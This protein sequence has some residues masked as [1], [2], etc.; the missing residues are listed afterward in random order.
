M[1][2]LFVLIPVSALA[3]TA[4]PAAYSGTPAVFKMV[5]EERP[6]PSSRVLRPHAPQDSLTV[7]DPVVG[8][9]E[10]DADLIFPGEDPGE[11]ELATWLDKFRPRAL[12]NDAGYLVKGTTPPMWAAYA[13]QLSVPE[14]EAERPGPTTRPAVQPALW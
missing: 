4:S 12:A 7:A 13:A 5:A 8:M 14:A 1:K 11:R 9:T 10:T 6:E 3:S 2:A